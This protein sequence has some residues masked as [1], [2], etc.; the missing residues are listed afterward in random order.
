M[1]TPAF[2][3]LI[4]LGAAALFIFGLKA[5]SSPRS[6]RLGMLLAA[7]GMAAAM[8]GT[9]LDPSITAFGWIAIGVLVG[10]ALGAYIAIVTPMTHMPQRTALSHAFGALAAALV[11]VAHHIDHG[12]QGRKGVGI[13]YLRLCDTQEVCR[14]LLRPQVGKRYHNHAELQVAL[15][16]EKLQRMHGY[17]K[18]GPR[19]KDPG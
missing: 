3:Q 9:L 5:M 4:Y 18:I 19:G 16:H 12:E 11:G 2:I 10:T 17:M 14:L 13:S 6:A 8:C 1:S 7:G 15:P